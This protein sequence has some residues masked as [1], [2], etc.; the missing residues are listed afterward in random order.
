VSRIEAIVSDFGGVL[1]SPLMG[2][3]VAFQDRSGI[4]LEAL[5]RAMARAAERAGAH[6]LFE[7]EKGHLTEAEF[8]GALEEGLRDELE[9]PVDMSGFA[10]SYFEHLTVN[11]PMVDY[12]RDLRA[13]GLRLAMLT[14]NVREW[15]PRWRAMVP[16]DELFEL[17]VDSAWVGMRKP[18]PAI[19]ELTLNR[20]GLPAHATLLV[21]DIEINCEAAREVGMGAVHF[22]DHEQAR[23]EIEEALAA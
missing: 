13:R 7:L 1:T 19:Y 21:D 16:V 18:E 6:P 22:R 15:E 8:L 9:R 20:L 23:G 17:V 11:E 5:G 12:L 2:S 10:D 4:P 14:N 3:F